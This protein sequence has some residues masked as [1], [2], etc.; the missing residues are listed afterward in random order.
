MAVVAFDLTQ[1]KAELVRVTEEFARGVAETMRKM[2]EDRRESWRQ[3]IARHSDD[4]KSDLDK[5]I[6]KTDDGA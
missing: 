3:F 6:E 4:I 1:L 5:I 2:D